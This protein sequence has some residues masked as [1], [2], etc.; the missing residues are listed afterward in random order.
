MQSLRIMTE[1]MTKYVAF[2]ILRLNNAKYLPFY[3]MTLVQID[4]SRYES[5]P[6]LAYKLNNYNVTKTLV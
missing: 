4:Q 1:I 6:N 3:R 2:L 5:E